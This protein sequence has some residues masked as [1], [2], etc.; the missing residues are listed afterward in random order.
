MLHHHHGKWR[1]PTAVGS[2]P[3]YEW[4]GKYVVQFFNDPKCMVPENITTNMYHT[5][6]VHFWSV[7]LWWFDAG[8]MGQQASMVAH[9]A[10][11]PDQPW[12][13]PFCI[14]PT[15]GNVTDIILLFHRYEEK[16]ISLV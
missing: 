3:G 11:S 10:S 7:I 12:K 8:I 5:M 13:G 15:Y 14:I 1:M 4:L 2:R 9:V 6:I 16:V